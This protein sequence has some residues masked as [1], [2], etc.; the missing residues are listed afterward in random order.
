MMT[1]LT[2]QFIAGGLSALEGAMRD[3]ARPGRSDAQVAAEVERGGKLIS[4]LAGYLESLLRQTLAGGIEAR[5]AASM[6][7]ETERLLDG[8]AAMLSDLE[9][10][11][12]LQ[13]L[14]ADL[15]DRLSE[16]IAA[17]RSEV[18]RVKAEHAKVVKFA[19]RER[20]PFDPSRVPPLPP[21]GPGGAPAPGFRD[22]AEVIRAR[23]GG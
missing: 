14:P 8:M 12:R 13:P 6:F 7:G 5:A 18:L 17:D 4:G 16:A 19:T 9:A 21:P 20:P 23:K 22:L 15:H 10:I 2:H 3:F 1:T 11:Q